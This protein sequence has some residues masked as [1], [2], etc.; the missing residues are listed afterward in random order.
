MPRRRKIEILALAQRI[1][2]EVASGRVDDVDMSD[3]QVQKVAGLLV[4]PCPTPPV[5]P[6]RAGQKVGRWMTR[7]AAVVVEL[8]LALS[9][10][11]WAPFVS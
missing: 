2:A 8:P 4:P 10:T 6:V 9:M 3:E 1:E 5:L 11:T 7:S